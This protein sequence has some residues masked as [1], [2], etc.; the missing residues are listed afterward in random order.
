MV[1]KLIDGLA[2]VSFLLSAAFVGGGVYSFLWISNEDNQK[3][4]MDSAVEKIKGNLP[5]PTVPK[6]T[7]KALPF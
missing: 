3:E 2:V 1:R 6:T 7:G 4:L 5:I